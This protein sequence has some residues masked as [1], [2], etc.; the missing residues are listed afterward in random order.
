M[1]FR[2]LFVLACLVLRVDLS[3]S[4]QTNTPQS[5]S[6]STSPQSTRRAF[7]ATSTA[8]LSAATLSKQAAFAANVKVTAKA[9]TFL[10]SGGTVKPISDIDATTL[11]TNARVAYLFQGPDAISKNL[12][13]EVLDLTVQRKAGT[14]P[15]VAPGKVEVLSSTKSF[16]DAATGMGL[17]AVSVDS[18]SLEKVVEFALGMPEGDVLLVGPILSRGTANDGKLVADTAAALELDVGGKREGGVISVLLDGPREGLVL[19]QGGYPVSDLLWYSR[20][21]N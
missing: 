9:H 2:R 11:F 6:P 12:V 10:T 18:D 4:Y 17:S 3:T 19:E 1:F 8:V 15:G 21:T 7:L 14:G 16:V 13:L 5:S 20:P